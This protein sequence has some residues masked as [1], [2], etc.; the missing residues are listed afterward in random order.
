MSSQASGQGLSLPVPTWTYGQ[1]GRL[2]EL[3]KETR[4]TQRLKLIFVI[5]SDCRQRRRLSQGLNVARGS[6][7]WPD[8]QL[9]AS[10]PARA[11]LFLDHLAPHPFTVPPL[12]RPWPRHPSPCALRCNERDLHGLKK[13]AI[14]KPFFCLLKGRACVTGVKQARQEVINRKK[15][16]RKQAN[17]RGSNGPTQ[18]K[19][20]AQKGVSKS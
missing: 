20:D 8:E 1:A 2:P 10:L 3:K 12:V 7:W 4:S 19:I 5:R 6:P 11:Q 14:V 13:R 9:H 18:Q 17:P 15:M 16:K